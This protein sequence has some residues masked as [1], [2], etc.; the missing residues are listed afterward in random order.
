MDGLKTSRNLG[1]RPK[2]SLNKENK[3]LREMILGALDK[4][5]GE[6]YLARQAEE[7]P[8]PFMALLGK[9][10][11]TTLDGQIGHVINWP[12]NAPGIES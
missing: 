9:V 7:N 1:G 8:G 11:P 3:A 2:G 12:V 5:G 4:C 6:E 10:L